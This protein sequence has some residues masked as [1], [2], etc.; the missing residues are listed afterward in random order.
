[1][2]GTRPRSTQS[3][4]AIAALFVLAP[5]LLVASGGA[6][7]KPAPLNKD[8]RREFIRA[9]QVWTPTPVAAMDL[10]AGPSPSRRTPL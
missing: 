5:L 6:G 9:A 8:S 10:R 3:S 4:L 7:P 1:M 2:G